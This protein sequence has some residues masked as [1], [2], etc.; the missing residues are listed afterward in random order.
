M[1]QKNKQNGEFNFGDIGNLDIPDI[2]IDAFNFVPDEILDMESRYVKPKLVP[3]KE[4]YVL[5]DNAE[6]F[7]KEINIDFGERIFAL[8][9]GSFIFGDFIEAFLTTKNAKAVNMTI[10]TLSLSQENVDSLHNLIEKGYI[11]NLTLIISDYFYSH[12]RFILIPYIYEQLD[13][14]N[15]FQLVV[16]YNHSKI[17]QFETLGGRKIVMHGS[18]NLRSSGNIEQIC[19][20]E[21]PDLYDFFEE[22]FAPIVENYSTINKKINR[23][24]EW[25]LIIKKNFKNY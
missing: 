3:I 21:N 2:D 14:N 19:I 13:I 22:R 23:K 4:E 24:E 10:S 8:V 15:S 9:S 12:E 1:E 6:K 17:I 20:E 11:D 25:N 7:A 18:S 16:A 5:Y